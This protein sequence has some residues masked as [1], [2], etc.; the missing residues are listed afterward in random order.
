MTLKVIQGHIRNL[1]AKIILAHSGFNENLYE[2]EY[3]EDTFAL[4]YI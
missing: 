3:H 2:C 1:Y 4:N